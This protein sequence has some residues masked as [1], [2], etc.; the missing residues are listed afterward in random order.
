MRLDPRG[1]ER[2]YDWDSIVDAQY[3]ERHRVI[4][5]A[6]RGDEERVAIAGSFAELDLPELSRRIRDARRLAV[7]NRLAPRFGCEASE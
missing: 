1:G 7:W 6:V 3:D 4:Q 5:V 2:I